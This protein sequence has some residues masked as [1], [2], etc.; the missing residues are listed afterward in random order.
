MRLTKEEFFDLYI[1]SLSDSE[2]KSEF[3][4]SFSNLAANEM[5]AI[6]KLRFKALAQL[7]KEKAESA[8]SMFKDR[9]IA[10]SHSLQLQTLL[11]QRYP[12]F[13]FRNLD[14]LSDSDLKQLS[15]DM[16][17]I[18]LIEEA[19]DEQKSGKGN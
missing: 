13:Q 19:E 1:G 11:A 15:E 6:K 14:K 10:N 18:N 8:I 9:L 4:I 16:D 17:L 7:G 2:Q 3:G 12:S 5:K